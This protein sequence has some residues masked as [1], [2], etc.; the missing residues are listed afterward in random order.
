MSSFYSKRP[1]TPLSGMG[2]GSSD[3][4][5]DIDHVV[6]GLARE[7]GDAARRA[8]GGG[9]GLAGARNGCRERRVDPPILRSCS[10][11][12]HH[13]GRRLIRLAPGLAPP[14]NSA[15]ESVWNRVFTERDAQHRPV[16]GL[17][18]QYAGC[19]PGQL[20]IV[21]HRYRTEVGADGASFQLGRD[22]LVLRG[23]GGSSRRW[24]PGPTN[25]REELRLVLPASGRR[26]RLRTHG[27]FLAQ[28]REHAGHHAVTAQAQE[29]ERLR[30]IAL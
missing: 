12:V 15:G 11:A 4:P 17:V 14:S 29:G 7:P 27:V 9:K 10:A 20:P 28:P 26:P 30:Q 2:P 25:I 23:N 6:A 8:D 16:H 22:G 21:E 19:G 24:R 13:R 3:P 5:A 18:A 1:P